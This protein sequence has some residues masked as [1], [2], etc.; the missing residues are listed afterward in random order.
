VEVTDQ[1]HHL[2]QS[3]SP[4]KVSFPV[5]SYAIVLSP[6]NY[7]TSDMTGSVTGQHLGAPLRTAY[8]A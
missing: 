7:A 3:I 5:N 8:S 2:K 1:Q 6:L 4:Q